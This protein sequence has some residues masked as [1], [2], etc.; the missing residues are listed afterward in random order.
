MSL[1]RGAHE[2]LCYHAS[3]EGRAIPRR[4]NEV[5]ATDRLIQYAAR[6]ASP[7]AYSGMKVPAGGPPRHV[8]SDWPG[9]LNQ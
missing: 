9:H 4:R 2:G 3:S 6:W 1:L 7:R 5:F 8:P